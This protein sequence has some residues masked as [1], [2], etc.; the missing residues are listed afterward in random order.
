M[1]KK[2]FDFW[3]LVGAAGGFW[4]YFD[5]NKKTRCE[6]CN[7]RAGLFSLN[8]FSSE[9]QRAVDSKTFCPN[10]FLDLKDAA[11]LRALALV[12]EIERVEYKSFYS[13]DD[14]TFYLSGGL[15]HFG[16]SFNTSGEFKEMKNHALTIARRHGLKL[17]HID[18]SY[19]YKGFLQFA[20]SFNFGRGLTETD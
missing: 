20:F 17:R 9:V 5:E 7:R 14:I 10:C 16:F 2:L 6:V 13:C 12:T 1:A 19:L 4:F 18:T 15:V 3:A 8:Y 11:L